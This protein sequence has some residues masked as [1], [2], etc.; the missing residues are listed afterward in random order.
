[1]I[2]RAETCRNKALECERAALVAADS[3]IHAACLDM[4][5]QWREIAERAEVLDR[6]QAAQG[7]PS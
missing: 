2:K 1:M 6:K 4:A 5:R 3:K 7:K